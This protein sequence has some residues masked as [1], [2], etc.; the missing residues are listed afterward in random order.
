[1]P[2]T[3]KIQNKEKPAEK[4]QPAQLSDY[5]LPDQRSEGLKAFLLWLLI[6]ALLSLAPAFVEATRGIGIGVF[7]WWLASLIIYFVLA[8]LMVRRRLR[9]HGDEYA[10]AKRNPRLKTLLSKGSGLVGITE[11]EAFLVNEVTPQIRILGRKDPYFVIITQAVVDLVTPSEL[12]CLVLRALVHARQGHVRRLMLMQFVNDTPGALRLLVWPGWLYAG[13]LR[14]RWLELAETTADRLTLLLVKN[15][16][17]L[18]S[19]LLK[20]HVATD[21]LMQES[22]VT[23]ADVD[24]FIK[25]GDVIGLEGTEISTQYKMG[26]AIHENPYLEERMQMLADWAK[27]PEFNAAM[28]KLA[29][30]RTARPL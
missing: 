26:Q 2:V 4:V 18:L 25:Q 7:I 20:L 17:L 22:K 3:V 9:M 1:M 19:A 27:S 10:L 11:P 5:V 6:I 24:N 30:A 12:D 29:Q 23:I 13:M 28:E 21:P 15:H 16:K 14:M 8:P